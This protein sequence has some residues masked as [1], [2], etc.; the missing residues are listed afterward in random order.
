MTLIDFFSKIFRIIKLRNDS[1]CDMNSFFSAF[2]SDDISTG[3]LRKTVQRGSLD[4]SLRILETNII[5]E[6]M[7]AKAAQIISQDVQAIFCHECRVW[8][9]NSDPVC[10]EKNHHIE[11]RTTKKRRFQCANKSCLH[12]I[13]VF[14]I[15]YPAV[16]CTRCGCAAWS[17][18]GMRTF[19]HEGSKDIPMD[20]VS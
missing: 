6:N 7:Q 4:N 14:A 10:E 11:R 15:T 12:Q 19:S 5:H 16:L 13:E 18:V 8:F 9:R 2:D 17:Q 1:F 3:D 20:Y